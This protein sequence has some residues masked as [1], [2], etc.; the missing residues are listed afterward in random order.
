MAV[1]GI[2]LLLGSAYAGGWAFHIVLAIIAVLASYEAYRLLSSDAPLVPLVP[3]V[4]LAA[5]APFVVG[6][7][8]YERLIAMFAVTL[9]FT[10]TLALRFGVAKGRKAFAA[11][12]L[13]TYP[14]LPVLHLGWLREL[15][16]W[17]AVVFLF[18]LIW[19]GDTAAY[20]GGKLTGRH[21]LAP[22]ISP[23]KTVEGFLWA[24]VVTVTVAWSYYALVPGWRMTLL[25]TLLSGIV[26]WVFGTVGDLFESILKR[27]ADVKDSSQLLSE[28]GGVLDRFDSLLLAVIPLYYIFQ[29][30]P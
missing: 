13:P 7:A 1:W 10:A 22:Y 15:H 30:L 9:L 4:A 20:A 12:L 21:L 27:S 23:R 3:V 16:G 28:H 29:W 17:Q 24:L 11:L 26:I 25:M 18:A 2:P 19:L 14:I 6:A 5:A 8:H